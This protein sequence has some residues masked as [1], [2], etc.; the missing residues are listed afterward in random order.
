M[1]GHLWNPYLPY[2]YKDD[3]MFEEQFVISYGDEQASNVRY[4][5]ISAVSL[6]QTAEEVICV[7]AIVN[8]RNNPYGAKPTTLFNVLMNRDTGFIYGEFPAVYGVSDDVK[9][10]VDSASGNLQVVVNGEVRWYTGEGMA[11]LVERPTATPDPVQEGMRLAGV[12][13]VRNLGDQMLAYGSGSGMPDMPMFE[14]N[15]QTGEWEKFVR[16]IGKVNYN[17]VGATIP[18]SVWTPL[19]LE[20][21]SHLRFSNE[22]GKLP[23]G[24]IGFQRGSDVDA[25]RI[26]P[27]WFPEDPNIRQEEWITL[28]YHGRL[29]AVVH[30][31]IGNPPGVSYH[32]VVEFPVEKA[33]QESGE[34]IWN[35]DSQYGGFLLYLYGEPSIYGVTGGKID[36][37]EKVTRM[38]MDKLIEIAKALPDGISVVFGIGYVPSDYFDKG[39]Y[40]YLEGLSS[41][42]L[43]DN[44]GI[45]DISSI[46]LDSSYYK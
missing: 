42:E 45:G 38:S 11:Q 35:G 17:Y 26:N 19:S 18:E 15:T 34:R 23:Y 12:Q 28:L 40:S 29:R 3:K 25:M 9:V 41:G 27:V 31:T 7:S 36:N 37:Y 32:P 6:E 33:D 13:R 30:A 8:R 16:E 44:R 20:K 14:L 46:Y 22:R 24:Y 43:V 4:K 1:P 2:P 5:A 21:T 10:R 39:L